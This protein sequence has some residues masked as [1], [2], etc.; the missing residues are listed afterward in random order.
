M[1]PRSG[2][3]RWRSPAPPVRRS[4]A[5]AGVVLTS[6]VPG[7]AAG[8]AVRAQEFHQLD[9]ASDHEPAR[10]GRNS[11]VHPVC[12]VGYCRSPG[13]RASM[14]MPPSQRWRSPP[15]RSGALGDD[16]LPFPL[17]PSFAGSMGCAREI[18]LLP[19]TDR[20]SRLLSDAVPRESDARHLP[21][22]LARLHMRPPP[23]RYV[24]LQ[25]F[26]ILSGEQASAFRIRTSEDIRGVEWVYRGCVSMY[27]DAQY[28]LIMLS[29]RSCAT[30]PNHP[31]IFEGGRSRTCS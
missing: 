17:R 22:E 15:G 16:Q 2:S 23:R 8:P 13:P 4:T 11:N 20:R 25:S 18:G 31:Q 26:K 27:I 3:T 1:N 28:I 29:N 14:S 21:D 6:G 5:A 24:Q 19:G 7:L 9:P 12:Q 10:T 30:S